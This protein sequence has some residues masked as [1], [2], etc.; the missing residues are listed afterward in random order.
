MYFTAI[1]EIGALSAMFAGETIAKKALPELI[2]RLPVGGKT[3]AVIKGLGF[4][5]ASIAS[6]ALGEKLGDDLAKE[7]KTNFGFNGYKKINQ[8]A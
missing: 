8:M 6:Y 4:V 3:G 1:K 5:A 2:K 7:V